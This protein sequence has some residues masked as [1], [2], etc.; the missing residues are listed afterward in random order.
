M[1]QANEYPLDRVLMA[2]TD[3][4]VAAVY[5]ELSRV[6]EGRHAFLYFR[7]ASG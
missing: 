1:M 3:M 2:L 7:K 4:G 6:D 5:F